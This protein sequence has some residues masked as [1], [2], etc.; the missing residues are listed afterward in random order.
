MRCWVTIGFRTT[1]KC[2]YCRAKAEC[3][4]IS[5]SRSGKGEEPTRR[6][7]VAL[8]GSCWQGDE[9]LETPPVFFPPERSLR[10]PLR[11]A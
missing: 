11:P 10:M 5:F 4:E 8:C 2:A 6:I 7:T 1:T 9:K 3:R